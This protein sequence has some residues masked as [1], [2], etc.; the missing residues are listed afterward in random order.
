MHGGRHDFTGP[1]IELPVVEIAF[2]NIAFDIAFRQRPGPVSA[3][4]VH[5]VKFA[6]DIEYREHELAGFDLYGGAFGN[7]VGRARVPDVTSLIIGL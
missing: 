1:D 2:H 3:G 7:I 5:Y 4:V 6:I